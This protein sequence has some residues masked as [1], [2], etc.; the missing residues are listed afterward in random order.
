M[1]MSLIATAPIALVGLLMATGVVQVPEGGPT[2]VPYS[3]VMITSTLFSL[4]GAWLW[5]VFGG[6]LGRWVGWARRATA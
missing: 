6:Q 4:P 5:G 1:R 3:F 2:T